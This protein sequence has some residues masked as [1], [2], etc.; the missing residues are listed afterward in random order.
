[1]PLKVFGI[2][3]SK[4]GTTSLNMAL[5]ILGFSSIHYPVTWSQINQHDAA[6]DIT[7]ASRFKELDELY[8]GSKFILTVRDSNK[9]LESCQ[10]HFTYFTEQ[11]FLPEN[12]KFYLEQRVKIY[13]TKI[14]DR[15]LFQEAYKNHIH[16][17]QNYFGHR[18]QDLLVIDIPAGDG[19]VELCSFLQLPA[20]KQAFPH[21]NADSELI[22]NVDEQNAYQAWMANLLNANPR[23]CVTYPHA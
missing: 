4:T 1:M 2:G 18:P 22:S 12:R 13:G 20:P 23:D 5:E 15:V 14:Y 6:T 10:N 7:I 11:K 16:N 19:W 9:W 21:K 17:V 8:P 3:L